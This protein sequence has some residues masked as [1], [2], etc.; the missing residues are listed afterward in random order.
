LFFVDV[1]A[2]EWAVLH[3]P[4][5]KVLRAAEEPIDLPTEHKRVLRY[6]EKPVYFSR[7]RSWP[8]YERLKTKA[9]SD[10][11]DAARASLQIVDRTGRVHQIGGYPD[12]VQGDW[13]EWELEMDVRGIQP[14]SFG[15]WLETPEAAALEPAVREWKLLLQLDS[16]EDTG[17][18]WIDSGVLYFWIREQDARAGNFAA[19]KLIAQF[20]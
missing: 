16:D 17:F 8:G 3:E 6:R 9:T 14:K 10:E 4:D 19:T 12:C 5:T 18:H 2:D 1:Q 13:M 15:D 7:R 11:D 20:C